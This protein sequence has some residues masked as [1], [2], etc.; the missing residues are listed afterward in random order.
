M[1]FGGLGRGAAIGLALVAMASPALAKNRAAPQPVYD[2]S[3]LAGAMDQR[4]AEGLFSGVIAVRAK[5]RDLF[6]RACGQADIV[7]GIANEPATRFKIYSTSKLITALV[8]M[9]LVETERMALDASIADYVADVPAE[10]REVT[11][12]QLLNHT[13]GIPDHMGPFIFH[14]RSEA[15]AAMRAALAA[16]TAEERALKGAPGGEWRYNNFGYELLADA[17]ANASDRPFVELVETLVLKPAGMD[18]AKIEAPNIILGHALPVSE[19]GLAIG[20]NGSPERLK[21]ATNWAFMQPGA[22]AIHATVQDFAALEEALRAGT[23]ISAESYAEM[24]RAPVHPFDETPERGVGLGIWTQTIDGVAAEGHSGGTNGYITNYMRFPDDDA[25]MIVMSNRGF[26]K[27]D[28][29]VGTVAGA[30][31]AAR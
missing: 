18:T 2:F 6:Q 13:S 16:L 15:P 5:G 27:T 9:K 17:A 22:G 29:I 12:R 23:I 21:Q 3:A 11:I 10:W 25:M 14:Y 24:K 1:N 4:C 19:D 28:W 26:T 7:N 31:K 20:Y 8:I 30:L